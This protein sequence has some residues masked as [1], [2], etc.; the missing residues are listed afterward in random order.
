MGS[1]KMIY[2][3]IPICFLLFFSILYSSFNSS[4]DNNNLNLSKSIYDYEVVSIEG[5]T[6][7]MSEYKGKNILI[8]NV[9][10]W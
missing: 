3:I 9:A 2:Y 8:V 10:S 5:D 4:N 6:I 7:S 1:V